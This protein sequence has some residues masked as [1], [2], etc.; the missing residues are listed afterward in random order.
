MSIVGYDEFLFDHSGIQHVVYR[1]G[2]GPGVILMHE[3]PGMVKECI[4]L[5]GR[6]V[7]EVYCVYMPLFFGKPY[8][9]ATYKNLL[10]VCISREFRVFAKGE[11]SPIVEW[12]KEL[13]RHVL[14]ER[15]GPGVGV[16]GMCL[17]GNFAISL[18]ATK[19]ILAPVSCQPSLPFAIG[20]SRKKDLALSQDE[21]SEIKKQASEGKKLLGFRFTG[22]IACPH[23]RFARL[24]N[25]IGDSFEGIEI[26]S[27]EGNEF[28]IRKR[29]HSVLT[30]DFADREGHPT[31]KA[32]ERV[33]SFFDEKL[34]N[35]D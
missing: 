21:L 5:A 3:L 26:D 2:E 15:G 31:K 35:I 10:K 19:E 8:E 13:G 29:A 20:S 18:M 11:T 12:L 28:G 30:L 33:L 34:K 22:D 6:L 32:L 1:K 24:K 16:I 23:E 7:D 17:T 27:S 25:E 4:E 14:K 9:K